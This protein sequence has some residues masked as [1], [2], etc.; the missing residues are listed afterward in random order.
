MLLSVNPTCALT[1]VSSPRAW[2][3]YALPTRVGPWTRF[4][5]PVG[6]AGF[7]VFLSNASGQTDSIRID[8][9]GRVLKREPVDYDYRRAGLLRAATGLHQSLFAGHKGRL[10]VGASGLVLLGNL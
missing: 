1:P 8:G 10:I 5:P 4:I 3:I 9:E 7:D 6:I 2:T